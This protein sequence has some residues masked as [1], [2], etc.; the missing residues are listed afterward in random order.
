MRRVYRVVHDSDLAKAGDVLVVNDDGAHL[1][2]RLDYITSDI[3]I[4]ES[5]D[6]TRFSPR[7][8]PGRSELRLVRGG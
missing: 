3:L 4:Q 8:R 5:L 1:Y 2:R 7:S 6:I